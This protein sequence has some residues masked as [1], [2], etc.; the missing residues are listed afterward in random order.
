MKYTICDR[1]GSEFLDGY[2]CGESGDIILRDEIEK[3][4][5]ILKF[6]VAL[7]IHASQQIIARTASENATADI[8]PNCA[9]ELLLR[10]ITDNFNFNK[11]G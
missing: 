4:D 11:V 5:R 8:C 2:G 1:C 10:N 3:S 6:K 9:V 7:S